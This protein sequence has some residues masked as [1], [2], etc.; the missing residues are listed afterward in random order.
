MPLPSPRPREQESK[1]V[2]R[3]MDSETMKREYPDNKQRVAVC[4]S[5][6]RKKK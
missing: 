2:G 6:W 3:C 5:Q 4:Y 1:F